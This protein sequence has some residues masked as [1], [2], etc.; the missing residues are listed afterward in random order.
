MLKNLPRFAVEHPMVMIPIFLALIGGGYIAYTNLPQE[1]QPYVESPTVGVIIRFPGVSAEDME[2]YFARPIE[3]KVSVL[4]DIQFIRS[5]SQEGRAEVDIGF[6]YGSDMNKNKVSVQTLLSNM[7]NELPLDKDNTTNPWV[8]HVDAQNVPILDLSVSR[9]GWNDIRLREFIENTIRDAFEKLP[10]VQSAIP[11][12]GKRRQIQVVVDRDRLGAYGL[13]ILKVKQAIDTTYLNRASGRLTNA[14]EEFLVRVMQRYDD[15]TKL[16]DIPVGSRDDRMIYLRDVA[17]VVD[18]Y[19]EMRSAYHFNGKASILLTIVKQPEAGDPAVIQPALELAREFEREY[20]GLKFE[21]AYNREDFIDVIRTNGWRQLWLAFVLTSLVL[22]VFLQTITPTIIVLVT[23]PA[24]IFSAFLLWGPF[25]Q[26]INTPTQMALVFVL[27][28]LVDDSVVLM[29]VISRHLKRGKTP[30]DAAIEGTQEVM[31]ATI[32]TSITFWV[33]LTPN[34]FLGGSFGA[35]FRGMTLPMI[36][37]NI[38]STFFTLTLNPMIA[39]YFFKPY[40][41]MLLAPSDR[42]LRWLFRPVTWLLEGLEWLYSKITGWSLDHRLVILGLA[43][44]MMYI[45]WQMWPMLGS[46]G[47][48][49]QDT[50]QAVGEVE[51]WPGT[52]FAETERITAEVEKILLK[53]PEVLLVSTQIGQEPVFGTFFSGFGVRTV[54]KAFFKIT[55]TEKDARLCQFYEKWLD[56]LTG[57]CSKKTGRDIWEIMDGIHAEVMHTIPGIRSLWLMEMGATPVNTARAPVEALFKG[58]DLETLAGFG[59]KALEIADRTPGLVQSFTNWSMTMPQYQLDIDLTRTKELGLTTKDI[60]LQAFYALQGGMTSEF[61]K[62]AEGFRHSRLL[63]RYREDQRVHP[64]DLEQI[65]ITTPGGQQVPLKTVARITKRLGT[66]LVYKEDLK[67]ALSVMGQY[68]GVGLKTATAGLVMGNRMSINLPKGYTVAPKGMMLD[69]LDNIQRLDKGRNVAFFLLFILLLLQTTSMVNTISI[70]AGTVPLMM[71]GAYSFLL[72]R[73]MNWSPPVMWGQTIAIAIVISVG[74]YLVDKIVQNR[75]AGMSRREAI[76]D[77][78]VTRL[79]PVLMTTLTTAMAFVPPMFAPPTGMDRFSPIA[80]GLIGGLV[81]ATIPSL[82]VVPVLYSLL[83]DI[84][85]FLAGVY[86]TRR[87]E[88]VE[89]SAGQL[90]PTGPTEERQ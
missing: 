78:G 56:P 81:A 75:Q 67:Y 84:K 82:L 45:A 41:E 15:P 55:L 59:D 38:F 40:Q 10:G 33:V 74:I 66:D 70:I 4:D 68:R 17:K 83:D 80:T 36:F 76:I 43:A 30:K 25:G 52:T 44:A 57:G 12:G 35:G 71:L 6:S 37:A 73:G 5:T 50:G 24:A 28:R 54:N 21:T 14:R 90:V 22:L 11:Y 62:P 64:E 47:M 23:L 31:F 20:P 53:H 42:A 32:A 2:A 61:F 69:M 34:L 87:Q 86:G 49:L 89:V 65:L 88:V 1:L 16:L 27:G 13:S 19:A 18:T 7:L 60:Q 39:A 29:D 85:E 48:P 63:I 79:R 3:Q 77:A 72:M 51:A 9:P 58:D 46:E 26:T 8:V